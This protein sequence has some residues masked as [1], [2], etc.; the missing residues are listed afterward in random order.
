[1]ARHHQPPA[2]TGNPLITISMR[3]AKRL[4]DGHVWAYRS[5]VINEAGAAAG[6]IVDVADERGRGLGSALYSNA[7]VIALRLLARKSLPASPA[8]SQLVPERLRDA[9]AYRGRMVHNTDAYRIVFSEA[10]GLPGLVIDRYNDL[11]TLQVLTQ[12]FDREELRSV[13]LN[14]ITQALQPRAIFERVD[15][16]IRELEKLPALQ[17]RLVW[18]G[19]AHPVAPNEGATRVGHPHPEQ[20]HEP[21]TDDLRPTT[22]FQMNGVRFQFDALAGQKTGAFLDQRENYA[23]VER[24]AHGEALDCFCYQG[25]FSLHLARACSQVAGVDS[26]RS[27]LEIAEQN[28]QLNGREIE[29]LEANA[30]DLLKDYSAAKRQYD[31]IVLDPPAFAKNRA[32]VPTALR[33]YKELNLRALRMLRPGGVLATCSCSHHVSEPDFLQM[34]ASSA[35]DAGRRVRILET[36]GAALDHPRVATVPET[37]YLKC[38]ICSV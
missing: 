16:R 15:A 22:V 4:R 10:D 19:L 12:A 8:I 5:D 3:A 33:G 37:A 32:S 34:L 21:T 31:I 20:A 23:A 38:V 14:E 24:Y 30:F 7:S 28:A 13:V 35:A 2:A 36:R 17:D 26:S 29:W 11:L 27:A 25:G 6:A 1:M 9:I 18:P